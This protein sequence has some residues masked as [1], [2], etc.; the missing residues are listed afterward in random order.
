[1]YHRDH[2]DSEGHASQIVSAASQRIPLLAQDDLSDPY[3]AAEHNGRDDPDGDEGSLGV[4]LGAVH[5]VVDGELEWQPPVQTDEH[6]GVDGD[7]AKDVVQDI[8]HVTQSLRHGPVA[9][10]AVD[11]PNRH[12]D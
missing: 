8:P 9:Q 4:A 1:M 12:G 3:V 7:A 2:T 10:G 11:G 6:D 5:L